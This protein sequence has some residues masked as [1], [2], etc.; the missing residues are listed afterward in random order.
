MILEFTE[1]GQLIYSIVTDSKVQKIILTYY[2]QG[3]EIV[4]DQ[5]TSPSV[6]RTHYSI[7]GDQL[8]LKFEDS[9]KGFTRISQQEALSLVKAT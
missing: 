9:K 5:P 1:K 7:S 2:I 4:T 6:E 8:F 3:A